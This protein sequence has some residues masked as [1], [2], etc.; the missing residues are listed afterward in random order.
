MAFDRLKG[1]HHRKNTIA[2][3]LDTSIKDRHVLLWYR[4]LVADV[5]V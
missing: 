2:L 4:Q 1:S 3:C 5:S